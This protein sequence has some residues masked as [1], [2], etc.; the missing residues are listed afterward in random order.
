[1]NLEYLLY[2]HKI[3]QKK[4]AESTNIPKNTINRYFNETWTTINK[5]HLDELCKYFKCEVQDIIEYKDEHKYNHKL[6]ASLDTPMVKE[7]SLEDYKTTYGNKTPKELFYEYVKIHMGQL[8]PADICKYALYLCEDDTTTTY[9]GAINM[10]E[11]IN[12]QYK[13][14]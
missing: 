13:P 1:M 6:G 5:E 12:D 14:K 2:K 10:I 11:K 8:T 9:E 4:L 3:T 7:P